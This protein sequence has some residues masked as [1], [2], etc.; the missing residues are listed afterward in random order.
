MPIGHP[1]RMMSEQADRHMSLKFEWKIQAKM[2]IQ[3]IILD[4]IVETMKANEIFKSEM[5]N[6]HANDYKIWGT[7]QQARGDWERVEERHE[8]NQVL[9]CYK[10]QRKNLYKES[11]QLCRT[12]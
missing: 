6:S 9:Q 3:E 5:E 2:C 11:D 10:N 12:L 4:I 7:S 8:E 1:T